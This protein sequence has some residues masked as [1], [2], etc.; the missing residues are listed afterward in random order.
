M[1]RELCKSHNYTLFKN[2]SKIMKILLSGVETNNKGAELM[3]YAILQEIEK[4]YPKAEVFI[5]KDN[6]KQGLS[7][8]K[9]SLKLQ[10]CNY[11]FID[12]LFRKLHI[13]G[14]LWRLHLP[15]ITP[16]LLVPQ[17]VEYFIDGSGFTFS[18]QWNLS[19]SKVN[20]WYLLLEKLY[21]RGCKI[22]FLPQA[23]GPAELPN[24]KKIFSIL[25]KYADVIM[26][27]EKVSLDYIKKSGVVD[28]KKVKMFTDFTSLVAGVFPEKLE[29]LKNGIAIIPNLRM[30]DK[31]K[32][33]RDDYKVL[34]SSIVN[35]GK[36]TGHIVYLLNH[37]GKGD[38]QF[39]FE[40]QNDLNDIEVVTGL[41]ALEV[42]GLISSA[43]I[44]ISSRFHGV[45]SAL[46][47]CVPCLATS[48]SHKYKE[49]FADYGLYNS[50]LPL[51][52]IE[53][54]VSMVNYHL[55]EHINKQIREKLLGEV[56]KI[57]AETK[58]MWEYIN[59]YC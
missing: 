38:E 56:I 59:D 27:R 1:C 3:L 34:L 57:Q 24:T 26:P 35:L 46:N 44:V 10:Y 53:S 11:R 42:K 15:Q 8:V 49:L 39:A 7:Y 45:A 19:N 36:M 48:W 43:Y 20:Y 30:I 47:C 29:R 41:N 4:K 12:Q 18:D 51:D 33:S 54:A 40:L 13:N 28:M 14:I 17:G 25:S 58:E 6:I 9:T 50:L 52:D 31:G 21:S 23:F 37:E 16:R 55:S 2:I 32:I 22:I 5:P